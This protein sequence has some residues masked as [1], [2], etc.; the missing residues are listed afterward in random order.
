MFIRPPNSLMYETTYRRS[1]RATVLPL[2]APVQEQKLWPV[3]LFAPRSR[4]TEK[5]IGYIPKHNPFPDLKITLNKPAYFSGTL[6]AQKVQ[7]YFRAKK[8]P[9]FEGIGFCN[10]LTLLW[11]YTTA[12]NNVAWFHLIKKSIMTGEHADILAKDREF[13]LDAVNYWQCPRN[14]GDIRQ[15]EM[16]KLFNIPVGAFD[17]DSE[18]LLIHF[19]KLKADDLVY[20]GSAYSASQAS[21]NHTIGITFDGKKYSIFDTGYTNNRNDNVKVFASLIEMVAEVKRVLKGPPAGPTPL[22]IRIAEG[23][24]FR[25]QENPMTLAS[26]YRYR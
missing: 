7:D 25:P 2:S 5:I 17:T 14:F 12:I 22:I 23:K 20:V 15:W 26:S 10:G 4:Y 3:T 11:L 13:F 9:V 21:T 1:F 24:Q 19:H 16:H 18:Q 8:R 6:F